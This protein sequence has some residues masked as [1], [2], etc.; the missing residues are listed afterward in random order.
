MQ[1]ATVNSVK[2]YSL[3][4]ASIGVRNGTYEAT[5]YGDNLLD[6]RGPTRGERPDAAGRAGI[7]APSG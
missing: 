4:R 2:S 6:E 3:Y 5:L 7:R 1:D